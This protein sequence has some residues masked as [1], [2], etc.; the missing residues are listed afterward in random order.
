MFCLSFIFAYKSIC[1]SWDR[2][3]KENRCQLP[4]SPKERLA[5][6]LGYLATGN[7][8]RD[9]AFAFK[10]GRSTIHNILLRSVRKSGISCRRWDIS[11]PNMAHETFFCKDPYQ[12]NVQDFQLSF[13]SSTENNEKYIWNF[14]CPL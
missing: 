11:S 4:I 10:V 3:S 5:I 12:Q 6:T 14:G 2:I 13:F 8:Q 7:S 1:T 9:L